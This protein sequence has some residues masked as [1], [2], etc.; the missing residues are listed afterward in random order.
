MNIQDTEAQFIKNFIRKERRE[1]SL[2]MLRSKNKRS[3]FLDRFNH[4]WEK[5]IAPKHLMKLKAKSFSGRLEEIAKSFEISE[6][7]LCY[8]ISY[9]EHDG[10]LLDLKAALEHC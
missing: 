1:R 10:K 8:F 7:E 5:M 4:R 9:D 3:D 2:W 6:A